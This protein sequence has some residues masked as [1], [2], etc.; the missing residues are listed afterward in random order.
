MRRTRREIR[1][2][3][4][5][6]RRAHPDPLGPF[7]SVQDGRAPWIDAVLASSVSVRQGGMLAFEMQP[8]GPASSGRASRW[9]GPLEAQPQGFRLAT[10]PSSVRATADRLEERR[11][12]SAWSVEVRL[13]EPPETSRETAAHRRF[14]LLVESA[15]RREG[16]SGVRFSP[17]GS[18]G[19]APAATSSSLRPRSPCYF[20]G[21]RCRF[22]PLAESR[23]VGS[24]PL[25]L[26]EGLGGR[27]TRVWVDPDQGRH[28]VILGETEWERARSSCVSLRRRPESAGIVLLDPI[29]D[30]ARRFLG[31]LP[32]VARPRVLWVSPG[33]SPVSINAL[34][35]ASE[36]SAVPFAK[37][38]RT[39]DDLLNAL[40]RTGRA[41]SARRHS[42]VRGSKR[43]C[44]KRWLRRAPSPA[45][46]WS[47]QS[48][49]SRAH[50]E[51][52]AASHPK[53]NLRS[54]NFAI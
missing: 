26:G 18:G 41:D 7:P 37:R 22:L 14:A 3:P 48:D 8:R 16:G 36:G 47:K 43:R 13:W 30:T 25:I 54:S 38:E 21:T 17:S 4:A 50:H 34:A 35:S 6:I 42:G 27:V 52:C 51:C 31:A 40:R 19:H 33:D 11:L 5:S 23:P 39:L 45:G 53:R 10:P 20:P 9:T 46:P 49:C 2:P 28:L 29:G 24:V 12:A 32:S 1:G 44:A 15:S